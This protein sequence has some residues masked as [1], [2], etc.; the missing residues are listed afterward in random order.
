MREVEVDTQ[1][2]DLQGILNCILCAPCIPQVERLLACKVISAQSPEW[3]QAFC[4][5]RVLP[6][7]SILDALTDPESFDCNHEFIDLCDRLF[8]AAN[9][10]TVAE[11]LGRSPSEACQWLDWAA[12]LWC[13]PVHYLYCLL[14]S[15][16]I[17]T[18][19]N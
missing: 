2:A 7:N 15:W 6:L 13:D 1:H 8:D 17:S 4:R 16:M 12:Q 5:E 10:L 9:P 19:V 18:E 11:R 3:V 14:N